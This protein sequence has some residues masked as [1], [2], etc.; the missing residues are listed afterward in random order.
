MILARGSAGEARNLRNARAT[1]EARAFAGGVELILSNGRIWTGEVHGR[2]PV[3]EVEALAIAG[4][5]IFALGSAGAIN[6]LAGPSTEVI[7]LGGRRA[8]PGFIDCHTHMASGGF[9]LLR[10]SLNDLKNEEEFIARIAEYARKT[11]PG[12]WILG[13]N[14]DEEDWP[15]AKLPTRQM[16]DAVTR[17]H[18]VFLQ[19]YDGHSALA[20]T[21]ALELAGVHRTTT[22]PP[23]GAVVRDPVTAEPTGV[24]KDT[25]MALVERVIPRPTE[26]EFEEALE[27]A[28][29]E[30]RRLGVTSVHNIS[31]SGDSPDGT[32]ASEIRLLARLEREGRLTCRFYELTPI[33]DWEKLAAAG[34]ARRQGS[35]WLRLGAVK[36]F[37]DG[38]LGSRTAWM[39]E[40]FEDAPGNR[41]LPMEIMDP[42]AKM[43]ALLRGCDAA[44]IQCCVHAIG[45]RANAEML[46]LFA[47]LGGE[48]ARERRF[49]IEHAQHLRA[50]DF[51]RFA[52]LGVIVS[53]Q[54]YHGADDGRWAEKRLGRA[55]ARTSYAWRSLLSAGAALAFGSD[56]PVAPLS[57]LLGLWAAVTRQT[58]DGKNPGGWFPEEKITVTE[59][60]RAY[61]SGA[62]YAEFAEGEKGTLAPGKFADITV[63]SDDILKIEAGRIR[64]TRVVLTVSGGRVVHRAL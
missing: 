54:P 12:R 5:R 59:A 38:S 21:R 55:R 63:L 49:R 25:A 32:F 10:L 22:D 46:D 9:D 33:A 28:L 29:A 41:G 16:I 27:A 62:A 37:A 39:F 56:W 52:A 4:G 17:E 19:R 26:A 48:R 47:R 51:S 15:T 14:W 7:D 64:E 58:L 50:Q 45:D 35:E 36:A 11:P 34:L 20:N 43:E 57:P 44:G 6:A 13:G 53:G 2:G 42:P 24:L 60:L 40:P 61:T 30:A 1:P 3:E 31:T 18:P 8:V 23:G